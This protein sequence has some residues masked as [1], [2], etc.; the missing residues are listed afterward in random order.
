MGYCSMWKRLRVICF[1]ACCALCLGVMGKGSE[2]RADFRL[3]NKTTSRVGVALGYKDTQ[4]WASEGWWN[5]DP[6][7]CE[8]LLKGS[9][10]SRYYYI[11]AIDYDKGGSW[12]GDSKMCTNKIMFTIRGIEK[13]ED[14]GYQKTGFFEV[15]TGD[16]YDWTVELSGA[17]TEH[18]TARPLP[19]PEP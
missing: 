15:D 10:I 18:E 6:N 9:L 3:C 5:L 16:E 1:L 8:T 4:G 14:R 12:G 11:F 7:T 19:K 17:K 2:A 13:C